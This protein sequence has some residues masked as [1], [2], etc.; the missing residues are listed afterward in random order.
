MHNIGASSNLSGPCA[1]SLILKMASLEN[2]AGKHRQK[3]FETKKMSLIFA[4]SPI[5]LYK[6]VKCPLVIRLCNVFTVGMYFITVLLPTLI[7]PESPNAAL[8]SPSFYLNSD[9]IL[10]PACLWFSI[11]FLVF[12]CCFL[13]SMSLDFKNITWWVIA[14]PTNTHTL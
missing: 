14:E 5:T 7:H 13:T 9:I 1:V 3:C 6:Y 4:C 10:F 8:W 2:L 12:C 11:I